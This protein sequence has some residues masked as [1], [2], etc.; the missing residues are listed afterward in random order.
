MTS[1]AT[2]ERAGSERPAEAGQ[3][4]S[5]DPCPE[6]FS[7]HRAPQLS[8]GRCPPA[9]SNGSAQG[10]VGGLVGDDLDSLRGSERGWAELDGQRVQPDA[11]EGALQPGV[12]LDRHSAKPGGI[13]D[14]QA[15]RERM[16]PVK[17][18]AHG[19]I[20]FRRGSGQG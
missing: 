10:G 5:T 19:Q 18:P 15:I 2:A 4:D 14:L 3:P 13:P 1:V 6:R 9:T 7:W 20:G 12:N 17:R 16:E 8:P 11:A